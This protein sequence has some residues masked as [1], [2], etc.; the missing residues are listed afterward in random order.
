MTYQTIPFTGERLARLIFASNDGFISDLIPRV[1]RRWSDGID[2]AA[3]AREL[4]LSEA[5]V[6]NIVAHRP[7]RHAASRR[8]NDAFPGTTR[9]MCTTAHRVVLD[10]V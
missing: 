7:R 9:N 2:T 5:T 3:I 1:L 8:K 4:M 6:Y 10:R